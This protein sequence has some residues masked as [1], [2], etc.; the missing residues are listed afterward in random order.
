MSFTTYEIAKVCHETNRAYC[1][2][3]GDYSQ[4]TWDDAPEWQKQSVIAGVEHVLKNPGA[5]P[6]DSHNSWLKQKKEEGWT[7]G[8]AKDSVQKLHPCFVPYWELPEEQKVKDRLFLA[9]ARSLLY[10]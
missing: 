9:V 1:Q 10:V 8:P 5:A 2:V 3:I 4:P 7:Y 6:E